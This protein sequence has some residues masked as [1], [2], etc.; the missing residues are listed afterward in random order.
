MRCLSWGGWRSA[1]AFRSLVQC[2]HVA[3]RQR[4]VRDV[5]N[6]YLRERADGGSELADAGREILCDPVHSRGTHQAGNPG[7][8]FEI[9]EEYLA[10]LPTGE[11]A[12]Q[13]VVE[14][15][16]E[17]L[18]AAGMRWAIEHPG[19]YGNVMYSQLDGKASAVLTL[20]LD[21]E[22]YLSYN[23]L[24]M[25]LAAAWQG[26]LDLSETKFEQYR[27]EGKLVIAGEEL[28][29]LAVWRWEYP[30]EYAALDTETSPRAPLPAEVMTFHGHYQ[31]GKEVVLSYSILG[32]DVLEWPTAMRDGDDLVLVHTLQIG[33]SEWE[34]RLIVGH[35]VMAEVTGDVEGMASSGEDGE[36]FL[37]I[38][39]SDVVR[40]VQIR[41]RA[42]AQG[43]GAIEEISAGDPPILRP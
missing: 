34:H 7:Q 31:Y 19:D 11:E 43:R 12:G 5:A 40:T 20:G 26:A 39:A 18:Q 42:G 36:V 41:R 23:V 3:V 24:R 33:P 6:R 10:G 38:P 22:I 37:H 4:S 13:D 2:G 25:R 21:E 17:G 14:A 29:G 30:G 15:A 16:A 27:G 1:L 9:T 32:R 35:E 28:E 8:Y